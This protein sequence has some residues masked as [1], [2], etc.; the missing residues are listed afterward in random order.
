[1]A[2]HPGSSRQS[3]LHGIWWKIAV[4]VG[5]V[6]LCVAAVFPVQERIRL[7]R[8]LRGGVSLIYRVNLDERDLNPDATLDQ[9]ITVLKERVNPKGILD[10]SF[11][12]VGRDRIEIVMPLP[13]EQVQALKR[14]YQSALDRLMASAQIPEGELQAALEAGQ[15]PQRFGGEG[16]RGRKIQ[17]LQDAFNARQAAVAALEQARGAGLSGAELFALEDA[18]AAAELHF[19]GVRRDVLALSLDPGRVER[20]VRLSTRPQQVLGP[21]RKPVVDPQSREPQMGPSP[22]EV[23]LAAIESRYPHLAGLVREV[24]AAYD[25][26][27]AKRTGFDDPE[28]LMRLLRGAGVLEFHIAVR[29]SDPQ[30]VN[31]DDLRAQLRDRG[32]DHTDSTVARWFRINDLKQWTETPED[33][34]ALQQDPVAFFRRIDLTAAEREGEYFLLLY[35]TDGASLVPRPDR[36]WSVTRAGLTL[37]NFGR[38]A[39]SFELDDPGGGYMRRLTGNH[40]GEPMAIVLD[41]EVYS[42]PTIQEAIGKNGIITGNFSQAELSYLIR[43]LASGALKARLTPDPIAI[44]TLGPSIGK[45]NLNRGLAAF[46]VSVIVVGLFMMG[47][48]FFAGLVADA[49][50]LL[51]GVLIFGFMA[52]IDG[53]FTLPGLAGVALTMGMAVDANVLIYERIREEL[54]SGEVDLRGAIKLGYSKAFSAILDGNLTNLLVCAVLFFMGTT[55]VKGFGLTMAI[56]VGATFFTALFITR[57]VYL[58]YTEVLGAGR[59]PM[60][61]TTIPAIHRA[62]Q[63]NVNWMALRRVC[64]PLSAVAVAGAWTL[65]AVRGAD[66]FDTEFRGGTAVTWRTAVVDE[67]RDGKADRTEDGEDARWWLPHTGTAGV[68][69]RVRG[70]AGLLEPVADPARRRSLLSAL[71]GAGVIA[72]L[73]EDPQAAG[74]D[75]E[76]EVVRATLKEFASAAVL[77]VGRTRSGAEGIE[78]QR[79]QVKVASPQGVAEKDEKTV[80]DTIVA[81]I[82][83]EFGD[84]LDVTRPLAFRGAGDPD[85]AD[86][87]FPITDP[88]LGRNTNRPRHADR[89]EPYLGGVAIAVDDVEPPVTAEDVRTRIDRMRSQPD[90]AELAGRRVGVFGLDPADPSDPTRGYLSLAVCVADPLLRFGEAE[91]ELWDG[92]LAAAEWR[93]VSAALQRQTSLEQVQSFSSA[94]SRTLTANAIVAVALSLLGILVYIWVRFGSIRYAMGGVVALFHDVSIAL[95]VLAATAWI[96]RL[97]FAS[98]LRIEEFRID[99]GVVAALLT[100]I[101]FSINDTIVIMDRIREKRGKLPIPTAG[102]VNR[103]INECMSRT[104]LTSGTVVLTV[105]VM[106]FAGGTGIRA[107]AFCMLVG[108]VSGTYSTVAIA[109]P[110]VIRGE[111]RGQ[112]GAEAGEETGAPLRHEEA[113][114]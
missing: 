39:V 99:M 112:E 95:G 37:D 92:R 1:M 80:T 12:V 3:A 66:L 49:A 67:G 27:A 94:V 64:I 104:I 45:D 93:L 16:E 18:A 75:P 11:T 46:I 14:S 9:V 106:Y 42:A 53:T 34:V 15:A 40:V 35:T 71:H 26:Y 68:E 43:V 32:P 87:T 13:G 48:Y 52:L 103:A 69:G 41:G 90:F 96:A 55:E 73:P 24:V 108:L 61:A 21:D 60:L 102:I 76:L 57:V 97:P 28:D 101:G 25:A 4:I 17:G 19:E 78:A 84:Q 23:E 29:S 88:V 5:V 85:H 56:G 74:A 7:G 109:A 36:D 54:V 31:P 110:W 38:D 81:A 70:L 91:F 44:N 100:I 63:P 47:Y 111:P 20:A 79:F 83:A 72:G 105:L 8:D 33:L 22:R 113:A 98:A 77:T 59:L 89:V 51:N 2:R 65:V 86:Y 58:L 30:G 107:F 10:I 114:V 50:L 6:G 82:V 62:M